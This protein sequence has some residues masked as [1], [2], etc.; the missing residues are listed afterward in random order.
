MAFLTCQYMSGALG[1]SASFNAII[2]EGLK[3][4]PTMYLLHGHGDD[5]TAWCRYT[6]VERYARDRG[7]AVI[8]PAAAHS[9]YCD[10]AHGD[11]YFNLVADEIVDYTRALFPLSKDREKTYVAGLSMGGYGAFKCALNRPQTFCAAASA[12]GAVDVAECMKM[13]DAQAL[14]TLIW[15]DPWEE[16]LTGSESD[17]YACVNARENDSLRPRLFQVC[18]DSDPLLPLNLKFKAFM[19]T[20]KTYTYR[21][22]HG[23]GSHSWEFWDHWL[24]AMMDFC[25]GKN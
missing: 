25:I 2:P 22:E 20:K 11:R 9:F 5:H 16:K 3:D 13:T 23:A 15:G 12:S 1:Y 7:I 18:G 19:D 17:L 24:P 14:A 8:M 21:Y 6:S 4:I 10:M